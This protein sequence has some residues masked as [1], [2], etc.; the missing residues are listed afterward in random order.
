MKKN[1][2]SS[3]LPSIIL[4]L[5][6]SILVVSC[7]QTLDPCDDTAKSEKA[8]TLKI[9]GHILNANNEAVVGEPIKVKAYKVPCGG[10]RKGEFEFTGV[11]DN[12]GSYTSTVVG[13]NLRNLDDEVVTFAVAHELENYHEQNFAQVIFKYNDFSSISMKEVHLYIYTTDQKQN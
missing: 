7:E 12:T 9:T 5:S 2:I 1:F 4:L 3:F 6:I 11:T 8:V 13:Y 10:E